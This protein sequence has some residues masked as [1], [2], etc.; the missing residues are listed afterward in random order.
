LKIQLET[1]L[2]GLGLPVF[3]IQ[4]E[5]TKIVIKDS[6]IQRA[7]ARLREELAELNYGDVG[8]PEMPPSIDVFTFFQIKLLPDISEQQLASLLDDANFFII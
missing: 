7:L 6:D 4:C 8:A 1:A 5:M 3:I 2:D